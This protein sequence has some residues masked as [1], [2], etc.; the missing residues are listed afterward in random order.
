MAAGGGGSCPIPPWMTILA[1]PWM[2]LPVCSLE[3]GAPGSG[4]AGG[5]PPS[6]PPLGT[7]PHLSPQ[8][9]LWGL[10]QPFI[11]SS[12]S[13][14]RAAFLHLSMCSPPSL[15]FLS[16]HRQPLGLRAAAD[17]EHRPSLKSPRESCLHGGLAVT[18]PGSR[19]TWLG[20]TAR[21]ESGGW[22]SQ[23]GTRGAGMGC[24]EPAR[25]C[26]LGAAGSLPSLSPAVTRR[27]RE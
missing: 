13:S 27:A 23:R 3:G 20:G 12:A 25:P 18:T 10:P 24:E 6:A 22:G 11:P 4:S 17:P 19:V 26:S 15:L 2:T 14:L 8:S 7:F 21:G 1:A 9:S 5:F 16:R